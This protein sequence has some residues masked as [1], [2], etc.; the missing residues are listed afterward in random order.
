M[1][2]FGWDDHKAT[3]MKK[4]ST[5][6]ANQDIPELKRTQLGR[7]VRGKYLDHAIDRSNI[8][9]LQPEIQNALPVTQTI[10]KAVNN[11]SASPQKTHSLSRRT[12]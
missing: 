9:M 8:V 2:K 3:D 12:K 6:T 4:A 5:K 1:F 11:M 10:V 7:G